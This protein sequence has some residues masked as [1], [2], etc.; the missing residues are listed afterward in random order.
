MVFQGT[1]SERHW[2]WQGLFYYAMWLIGF[3]LFLVL[4]DLVRQL[5]GFDPMIE[6]SLIG[7]PIW[8]FAIVGIGALVFLLLLSVYEVLGFLRCINVTLDELLEKTQNQ[9]GRSMPELD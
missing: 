4:G 8:G 6:G 5:F 9:K 1:F 3:P 2:F 7:L